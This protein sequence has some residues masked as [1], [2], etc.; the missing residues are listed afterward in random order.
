MAKKERFDKILVDKGFFETKN[1]AQAAILAGDVKLNGETIT[2]AGHPVEWKDD[3]KIEIKSLPFVSRGGLKLQKALDEFDIDLKEK[4]CL[5]AGASTGGFTDCMLQYGAKKVYAVDVGYGQIAWKLRNDSRVKVVERTNVKN[6][7]RSDIYDENDILPDFC[8]MDLSF[9]SITKV[10]GNIVNLLS[11]KEKSIA[12][13]IKPQFEAGREF[14]GKNG[15]VRE[16]STHI[17]VINDVIDFAGELA[18]YPAKFTYSPIKGPAGNIEYLILLSTV[19][20]D[21]DRQNVIDVVNF[22]HNSDF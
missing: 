16:K 3:T 17:K 8:A 9:I 2:K 5:D 19:S 14:V 13:L 6:C 7:M 15:V 18:L 22:A 20:V 12:A 4:I 11:D 1:K 10:L 21:F